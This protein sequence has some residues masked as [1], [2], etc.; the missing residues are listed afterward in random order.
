MDEKIDAAIANAVAMIRPNV[1]PD[2]AQ[3][4]AQA[5]LNL[6][7]AKAQLAGT[8]KVSPRKQGAGAS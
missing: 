4:F 6:A 7:H 5:A 2:D 3:K 1:K 8:E